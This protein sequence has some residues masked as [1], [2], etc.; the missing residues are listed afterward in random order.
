MRLKATGRL[1]VTDIRL[2]EIAQD[3]FPLTLR[4][5]AN[6]ANE[7]EITEEEVLERLSRLCRKGI[8]RKVGPVLD[9]RRVGLRASTLI[10]M[11][12]PE[13]RIR[14]VAQ[15][16][17]KHEE[18]SHCHQ[19]EHEYNFWFTVAAH[20]EIEL[21]KVLEM[22]KREAQIV[23][24]DMLDLRPTEIFKIDVRFKPDPSV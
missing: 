14:K 19:R 20:D 8:V 10:A 18:V 6:I 9:P 1:D 2:L 24:E 4:P 22:I 12:V 17:S 7:L 23:E 11:R 15:V 16:V 21:G 3:E 13:N 5:W